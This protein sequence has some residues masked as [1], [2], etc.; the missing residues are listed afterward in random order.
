MSIAGLPP[1]G[2]SSLPQALFRI[3][4]VCCS[5]VASFSSLPT[6]QRDL[7]QNCVHPFLCLVTMPPNPPTVPPRRGHAFSWS[8]SVVLSVFHASP[9]SVKVTELTFLV[10][11][12]CTGRIGVAP[13]RTDTMNS[14]TAD[15]PTRVAP[16]RPR[17][18]TRI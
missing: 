8:S 4:S 12:Q 16:G 10:L 9:G 14:P 15:H 7:S 2:A 13:S 6:T 11:L 1:S 5:Q 17:T 3:L 18:R